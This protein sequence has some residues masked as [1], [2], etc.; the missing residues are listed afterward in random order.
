MKLNYQIFGEGES[1]LIMLHAFPVNNKMF[2]KIT[3]K[4]LPYNWKVIYLDLPGYGKSENDKR[5]LWKMEDY[6]DKV[7]EF[8]SNWSYHKLVLGGVSMGGYIVMA[9]EK[10]F[11]NLVDGY[12]FA[13]TRDNADPDGGKSRMNVVKM[14]QSG[15]RKIYL[16]SFVKNVLSSHTLNYHEDI[17]DEVKK[18]V[19]EA[20]TESMI[21]SMLGMA[22]REESR[23][24][25]MKLKKPILIITGEE[26][27][28][29]GEIYAD[30]MAANYLNPVLKVLKY[31]GHFSPIENSEDF[32]ESVKEFLEKI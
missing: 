9:Y 5:E 16:D 28:L 19:D 3:D 24:V 27:N 23:S 2:E 10:L 20:P 14:L 21:Q 31:A 1:L 6:A 12:I 30:D 15:E 13:N 4:L 25:F 26:D 32:A 29:T 7:H 22:K 11:P 18:L 17:V 8:L